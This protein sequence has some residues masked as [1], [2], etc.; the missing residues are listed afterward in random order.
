VSGGGVPASRPEAPALRQHQEALQVATRGR[1]FVDVT[2]DVRAV[3]LRSGVR[4]GLCVVFCEHTSAS[5]L[6]QENADPD[7]RRDL[8]TFLSRLAPDGDPAFVHDAEGPDDMPA[9]ARSAVTR[10]SESIPVSGG[11]LAL[12]RWQALYL[13]EH[14][15]AGH[16]R[17]LR[18]HVL[19]T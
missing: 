7:V 19:G 16:A 18:V 11:D 12:G 3:V 1:G 10:T 17:T 4:V 8:E 6:V 13:V 9:H 15:L 5:L 2:R 14:R